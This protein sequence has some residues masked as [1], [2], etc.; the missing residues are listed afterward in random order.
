MIRKARCTALGFKVLF[1]AE[2]QKF[3]NLKDNLQREQWALDTSI[4]KLKAISKQLKTLLEHG[5]DSDGVFFPEEIVQHMFKVF[6]VYFLL[7]YDQAMLLK[8]GQLNYPYQTKVLKES[9]VGCDYIHPSRTH[10][11][12]AKNKND[13]RKLSVLS[14]EGSTAAYLA[15]KDSIN[16]YQ[17]DVSYDLYY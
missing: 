1:E 13:K 7:V 8:L 12:T 4:T 3:K 15:L 5:M 10:S 16:T 9:Y 14:S 6:F 11:F 17:K 2:V